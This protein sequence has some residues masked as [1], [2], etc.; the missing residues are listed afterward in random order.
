[1]PAPASPAVPTAPTQIQT[2][3]LS[4]GATEYAYQLSN[5]AVVPSYSDS[6]IQTFA[7]EFTTSTEGFVL[8]VEGFQDYG[9]VKGFCD[10]LWATP[11]VD[12][13]AFVLEVGGAKWEGNVNPRKPNAG[14][15]AG[16]ALDFSIDL[17]CMG[18]PTYTAAPAPAVVN[19]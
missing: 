9:S 18:A 7:G 2:L 6:S 8:H 3:T 12:K 14:G 1:M 5:A 10:L 19:P 4:V 17:P 15:A 11:I 16:G 13:L